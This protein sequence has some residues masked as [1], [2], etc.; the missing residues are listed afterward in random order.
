MLTQAEIDALLSGAIEVEQSDEGG[1][2]LA[3]LMGSKPVAPSKAAENKSK[4]IRPYNFWSPDR[5]SKEQMRAVELVH[6]DLGERLTSTLPPFLHA[7]VRL[8]VVHIEQGRFDDF[9]RDLA[10]TSLYH[11]INLDPL[12]GRIVLTISSEISWV[13]LGRML[14]GSGEGISDSGPMTEIGQSLMNVVAGFML[15]DIK[16]AWGKVVLLEPNIEDS[17]TNHHW[18]QMVMGNA[19]VMLVTFE[20]TTGDVTGT[21]SIYLP[22]A[23]L[24]PVANVLNPHVWI[25]G[26]DDSKPDPGARAAAIQGLSRVALSVQ[27]VLGK[28]ELTL[29]ELSQ[30]QIDD[31][32]CLD[33]RMDH[34]LEIKI[35]GKTRF[36]GRAGKTGKRMAVEITEIEPRGFSQEDD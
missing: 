5:F 27:V 34:D 11:L 22:F 17:T 4:K 9:M 25:E 20:M 15:N 35:S 33:Q 29:Q 18:V 12:P 3:E 28:A 7:E 32:I 30:L 10:P 31:V 13:I 1:V 6:E 24:K 23:M 16:A 2:N 19:R 14:G 36:R 8:R 26:R 21:M